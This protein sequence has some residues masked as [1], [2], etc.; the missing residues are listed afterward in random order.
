MKMLT[1]PPRGVNKFICFRGGT[2]LYDWNHR[3]FT[4]MDFNSSWVL[5]ADD[6]LEKSS[7]IK[8]ED[9]GEFKREIRVLSPESILF[10]NTK[11]LELS[12][13]MNDEDGE[14]EYLESLGFIKH[15]FCKKNGAWG[16]P[17]TMKDLGNIFIYCRKP[18]CP[19]VGQNSM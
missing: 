18:T 3:W 12:D 4:M 1:T 9:H 2:S 6:Y 11:Y 15:S 5:L 17:M 13:N 10:P 16:T 7:L 8:V 14:I 19:G